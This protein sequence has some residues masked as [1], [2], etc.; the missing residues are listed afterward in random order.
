MLKKPKGRELTQE[1]KDQNRS[2]SSFRVLFELAIAGAKRSRVVKDRFRCH[3]IGFDDLSIEL[4]CGLHNLRITLNY[5]A[6]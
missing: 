3:K 1:Q 4:A 2:I 6:I 5:S